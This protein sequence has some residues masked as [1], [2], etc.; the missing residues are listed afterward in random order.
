MRM[1]IEDRISLFKMTRDDK[2]KHILIKV[3][4]M[5]LRKPG[6]LMIEHIRHFIRKQYPTLSKQTVKEWS[7]IAM[8]HVLDIRG[9]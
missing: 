7:K 2:I 1:P 5:E 9:I 8:S 6:K 3:E 4:E